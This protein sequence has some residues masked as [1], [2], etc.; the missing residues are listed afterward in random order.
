MERGFRFGK[1]Q[2]TRGVGGLTLWLD[3]FNN[4]AY[5][6]IKFYSLDNLTVVVGVRA[7]GSIARLHVVDKSR[8]WEEWV[9]GLMLVAQRRG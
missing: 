8:V 6:I 5:E 2:L 7:V 1:S 3:A 9:A 4:I